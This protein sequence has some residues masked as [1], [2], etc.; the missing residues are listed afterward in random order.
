M[1]VNECMCVSVCV[2]VGV[3]VCVCKRSEASVCGWDCRKSHK[4]NIIYSHNHLCI[5]L[6][7]VI[8][9]M[10]KILKERILVP[11][12]LST[13]LWLNICI[14]T[15][16]FKFNWDKF[17]IVNISQLLTLAFSHINSQKQNSSW[18]LL[19][20]KVPSG[21]LYSLNRAMSSPGCEEAF[22]ILSIYI[23]VYVI[24]DLI[25]FNV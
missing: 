2:C 11:T 6:R 18:G 10:I 8:T 14:T 24:A 5:L 7:S 25:Y 23:H 17:Q 19:K 3:C 15:F 4:W 9:P 12:S 1:C 20:G 16:Y 13:N 21:T 22:Y